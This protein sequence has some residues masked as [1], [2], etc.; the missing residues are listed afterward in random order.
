M[1]DYD[2]L[3][4]GGELTPAASAARIDVIAAGTEEIIGR[5]PEADTT[6][7][8]AAVAAARRSLQDPGGWMRWTP[9]D[10]SQAI[11][12]LADELET[13][14]PRITSLVAQQNGMPISTANVIESVLPATIY[15]YYASLLR[16]T[17]F[18][19]TRPGLLGGQT[20]VRQVPV[21][22]VAAIV[23]WN[24]PNLITATKLAPALAAGCT[25]VIKPSPEALL[26]SYIVAEAV[27]SAGIPPG[28]VNIVPG[29]ADT[30]AYL[31]SHPDVGKVS[32]TGST[33]V[34]RE[35]ARTCG[36]LLRPT[37]LE[38]GGK[39]AAILLD[40]ADLP[41]SLEGL[42]QATLLNNGQTCVANSRILVPR[43]RY[44]EVIDFF[45]AMLSGAKV[46]DP[47]DP[48]TQVG[49]L[50]SDAQRSRVEGFIAGAKNGARLITGGGRPEQF[51]RG[52]FVEPTLFADVDPMSILGQQEVFGPLLALMPYDTVDDAISIANST[53]YGLAGTIWT[54]R[55][56]L[57]EDI[58]RK[59][60]S[61]T[62]GV[63]YYML[64]P[65][66]PFGGV[67]ASGLG[68]ELGPEGLASCLQPQT[69]YLAP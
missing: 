12:R 38:L 54:S 30:G 55:P 20:I 49:P 43:K 53:D 68:R 7:V 37:T 4:I 21:G 61:G 6:D 9:E 31:V 1:T 29:G 41:A 50:V 10:R 48:E 26:D 3:F 28:V 63:N 57:G 58:A 8:D 51:D 40:D 47:L 27:S 14:A 25:V 5:A 18:E 19:E 59:V 60:D 13:R 67:K 2:T 69:I 65:V 36:E 39:S 46:G 64:D 24:Y 23:P 42:F 56:K 15:R 52:W 32:F 35:I 16:R 33:A 44:D 34:G 17:P 62:V 45:A 22:V 66:A 11:E